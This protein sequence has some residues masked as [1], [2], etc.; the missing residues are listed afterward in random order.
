MHKVD[1]KIQ[2]LGELKEHLNQESQQMEETQ[3][4]FQ[5]AL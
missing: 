5:L 1:N 3:T 2:A 4:R